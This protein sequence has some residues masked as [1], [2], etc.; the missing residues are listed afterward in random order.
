[1]EASTSTSEGEEARRSENLE[2]KSRNRKFSHD[3]VNTSNC[4]ARW[5]ELK[6]GFNSGRRGGNRRHAVEWSYGNMD[7]GTRHSRSDWKSRCVQSI[8]RCCNI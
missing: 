8:G 5:L 4:R 3:L 2:N 6:G 7:H 1:M